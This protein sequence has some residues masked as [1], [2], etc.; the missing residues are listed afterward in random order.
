[1]T[2][3]MAIAP[4][5]SSSLLLKVFLHILPLQT[6][7]SEGSLIFSLFHFEMPPVSHH[8]WS[9]I[10]PMKSQ[11]WLTESHTVVMLEC[12]RHH[13]PAG[14]PDLESAQTPSL[15][16]SSSF[17]GKVLHSSKEKQEKMEF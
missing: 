12:V 15:G 7:H 17:L 3:M 2:T 9:M 8:T 6:R 10:I 1:M 14:T 16:S 13:S 5:V 4:W 11:S